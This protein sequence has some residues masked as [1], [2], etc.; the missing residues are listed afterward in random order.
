[1]ALMGAAWAA[2]VPSG[3]IPVWAWGQASPAPGPRAARPHERGEDSHDV[4]GRAEG[5]PVHI[6]PGMTPLRGFSGNPHVSACREAHKKSRGRTM[7]GIAWPRLGGYKAEATRA[8][9]SAPGPY[10]ALTGP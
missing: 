8:C 4:V 10:R 9:P 3:L 6:R 1:M 2:G 5:P 7:G